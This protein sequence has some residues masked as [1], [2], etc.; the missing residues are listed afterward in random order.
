MIEIDIKFYV[1]Q[2][3]KHEEL[4]LSAEERTKFWKDY[5]ENRLPVHGKVTDDEVTKAMYIAQNAAF[6][7]GRRETSYSMGIY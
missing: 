2:H 5:I 3:K 6:E 1:E 7:N 4:R